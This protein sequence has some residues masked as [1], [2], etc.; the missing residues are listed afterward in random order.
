[1]DENGN[2]NITNN[3]LAK[4][5]KNTS[6]GGRKSA[7][8]PQK[9]S[10]QSAY[11][12]LSSSKP[13][14]KRDLLVYISLAALVLI[15]FI[16][17]VF[18]LKNESGKGFKVTRGDVTLLTYTFGSS[19]HKNENYADLIEI[20]KV[21][22]GY[23]IKIYSSSEKTGYNV[24][25]FNEALKTADVIESNCSERKDCYHAPAISNSGAIYCSPHDLKITP[26]RGSADDGVVAG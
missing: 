14:Y 15:L 8:A 22:D 3:P 25:F 2:R 11:L 21:S 9:N 24:I 5:E 7:G 12:R 20:E 6:S 1:M 13:F 10:G 23:K 19:P 18:P 26:I 17:F 16:A 4:K